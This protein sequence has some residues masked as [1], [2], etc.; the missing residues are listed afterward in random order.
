[1]VREVIMSAETVNLVVRSILRLVTLW[2]TGG[3]C[4]VYGRALVKNPG[5]TRW[6]W[7]WIAIK[8]VRRL[9]GEKA[10]I[11]LEQER[12]KPERVSKI[13]QGGIQ[14]GSVLL[15]LGVLQLVIFVVQLLSRLGR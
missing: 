6:I 15:M 5:E 8:L 9:R 14:A 12:L 13:G 3:I 1:M 4:L 2:V 11:Q 7:D 10:A